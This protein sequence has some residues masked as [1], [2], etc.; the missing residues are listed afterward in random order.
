MEEKTFDAE[1][2]M[3]AIAALTS[4]IDELAQ[5]HEEMESVLYD[6]IIGQANQAKADEE[7]NNA[8][9]DFRCKYAEKLGPFEKVVGAIEGSDVFKKA[10]DE[11]NDGEYTISPDEYVDG[12]VESL[13][14]QLDEV[15]AAIS[16]GDVAK[17]AHIA[18]DVAEKAE[19]VAE[20][21][22]EEAHK[23]TEEKS[24]EPEADESEKKTDE[25]EQPEEKE[26]PE[27]DKEL[28]DYEAELKKDLE[29]Q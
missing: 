4:K 5:K 24:E 12:L 26:E 13:S 9:S 17:A 20:K 27:A 14:K 1:A 10:F 22:D 16:D 29:R 3:N 11:Y 2:V 19:D 23:E 8:L 7:Y 21:V 18:E 6:G 15:K 25:E 28:E